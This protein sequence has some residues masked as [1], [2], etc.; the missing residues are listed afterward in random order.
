M[1]ETSLVARSPLDIRFVP[2]SID[3]A[4]E[5]TFEMG[6]RRVFDALLH[7]GAWWPKRSQPGAGIVF[8]PYVGGRFFESWD[9][10]N[11]VLLGHVSKL[12]T[13]DAFAITGP[14]GLEGP[15]HGTWNVW[16][17]AVEQSRTLLRGRH[18]AFGAIDES[19]QAV[20]V[21]GWELTYARL[22]QYLE[23]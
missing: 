11:G 16:L 9:D 21:A 10:G 12:V 14:L 22:R 1:P 23:A 20:T 8:E 17:E 4:T 3:I 15:V 6:R 7:I 2:E 13:P 19:A 5:L 18:R